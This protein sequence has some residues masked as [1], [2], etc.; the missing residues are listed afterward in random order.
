ML[1]IAV[2]KRGI[3]KR[4]EMPQCLSNLDLVFLINSWPTHLD[5][6][7]IIVDLSMRRCSIY[8]C[9][10]VLKNYFVPVNRKVKVTF[11][12]LSFQLQM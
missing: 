7:S 8:H 10:T 4:T 6:F 2:L 9:N 1:K 5:I 12:V 11:A 3:K